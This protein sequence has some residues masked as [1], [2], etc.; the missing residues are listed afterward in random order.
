MCYSIKIILLVY[1]LFSTVMFLNMHFNLSLY[2]FLELDF[3]LQHCCI[4]ARPK[5]FFQFCLLTVLCQK[6][7]S[8]VAKQ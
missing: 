5:L 8:C 7:I 4:G 1:Y 2:F 3:E 6:I